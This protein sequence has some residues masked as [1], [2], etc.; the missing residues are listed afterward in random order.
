LLQTCVPLESSS[1]PV[2][3]PFNFFA[4]YTIPSI[5]SCNG[6]KTD[7]FTPGGPHNLLLAHL[8]PLLSLHASTRPPP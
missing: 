1:A 3:H 4:L 6:V 2:C 7:N 8:V 5:F